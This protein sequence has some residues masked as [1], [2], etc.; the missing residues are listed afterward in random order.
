MGHPSDEDLLATWYGRLRPDKPLDIMLSEE[1]RSWYVDL[2]AWD[3]EHG[4]RHSLRGPAASDDIIRGIRLAARQRHANSTHLFAGFRGTGKTTEL[5]RLALD[6]DAIPDPG[7]SVLRVNARD[8]N[9]LNAALSIEELVVLLAAGI[10]EAALNTLGEKALPQLQKVGVWQR[11][12]DRLR[13]ALGDQ[14]VTLKLGFADLKPALFEGKGLRDQLKH[15]LGDQANDKLREFLHGFV[16]EIAAAIA[17]RQ[18]VVLVDDLDKYTVPTMRVADVYQQMADLFFHHAPLLKL[19]TCH[20]I[21]TIPP[22]LAFLNQGITALFD[23]F[24]H[25]LPSVKVQGRPPKR[26]AHPEGI[27][28]LTRLISQRVDLAR[29]FGSEQEPC[30]RRLIVASGGNLRDLGILM[31]TVVELAL[32]QALPVTLQVVEDSISR[33]GAFRTLLKDDLDIL[34]EVSKHGDLGKVDKARLGAFAGAMDQHLMLCYWNGDFWY[35][36]HPVLMPK[37]DRARATSQA[38]EPDS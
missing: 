27:A 38:T 3:D 36:A 21:Y 16:L 34:L 9:P 5:S 31:R 14:A 26:E 19:P 15:A 32:D 28:S 23:G 24:L 22:Y 1:D 33:F 10:G 25:V 6:L 7:F 17:P 35:D 13:Q 11:V 18:M 4:Q 2:D 8:Y 37:L 30:M 20:T 12:H 29:L